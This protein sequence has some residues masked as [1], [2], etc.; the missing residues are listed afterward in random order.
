MK[1][2]VGVVSILFLIANVLFLGCLNDK[3]KPQIGLYGPNKISIKPAPEGKFDT[4][5]L[6]HAKYTDPDP[7][8]WYSD[9]KSSNKDI[10]YSCD[11]EQILNV[12]RDKWYIK[13]AKPYTITYTVKDEKGLE[14]SVQRKMR[15][16]N[17]SEAFVPYGESSSFKLLRREASYVRRDTSYNST[18]GVDARVAGV[19][20]FPRAYYHYKNGVPEYYSVNVS[21]YSTQLS[22]VRDENIGYLGHRDSPDVPFYQALNATM[23][24]L[25]FNRAVNMLV[26]DTSIY[27]ITMLKIDY[28]EYKDNNGNVYATIRGLN[29]ADGLP[30]STVEYNGNEAY[31]IKLVYEIEDLRP[32][33]RIKDIV[34]EYYEKLYFGEE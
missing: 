32:A 14:N 31:R 21:M 13:Q 20:R 22:N 24:N 6:L 16:A 4:V 30:R 9:N 33:V 29:G 15:C 7:A 2:T 12:A 19:F 8:V 10:Q 11:I 23:N 17:V 25:T 26:S 28:Q 18:L 27:R 5:V 1:K 34:T 3:V